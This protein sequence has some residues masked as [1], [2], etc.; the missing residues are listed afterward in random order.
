MAGQPGK[1]FEVNYFITRSLGGVVLEVTLGFML[2]LLVHRLVCLELQDA[3][4]VV[5]ACTMYEALPILY[6]IRG[7]MLEITDV[8]RLEEFD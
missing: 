4:T 6:G 1:V 8:R 5:D 2:L 7:R 3:V